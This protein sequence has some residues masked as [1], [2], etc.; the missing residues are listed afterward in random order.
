MATSVDYS[1]PV[2]S[3]A[4]E[5]NLRGMRLNEALEVLQRHIDSAVIM[6]MRNFAVIHGKGDGILQRGV[7]DYL[8]VQN[9]V[10][11]F[12]FSSP[13]LGGFGR[14]EVELKHWAYVSRET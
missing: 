1:L 4:P 5:L 9:I 10:A 14:T 6:G 12:R 13:E 2:P 7:H 3:A 11:D 8:S